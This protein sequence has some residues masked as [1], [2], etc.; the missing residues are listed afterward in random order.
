LNLPTVCPETPV[1]GSAFCDIHCKALREKG[2]EIL[3]LRDF[4]LHCGANPSNY[5]KDDRKK[6]R[7]RTIELSLLIGENVKTPSAIANYTSRNLIDKV[8]RKDPSAFDRAEEIPE[9]MTCTKDLGNAQQLRGHS[10]GILAMIKGGGIIRSWCHIY[11]SESLSQAAL[12]VIA[13]FLMKFRELQESQW[14]SQ[15]F[16][17]SYDNM[18]Q[19]AN[20]KIWRS[21]L[22]L[23]DKEGSRLN[24]LSNMWTQNI[25]KI[26]DVLHINNHKRESCKTL[27]NP[28]LMKNEFEDGN[29]MVCEA[30]FSWLGKYKKIINSLPKTRFEFLLHRLII[31][32][33]QYTE[34]CY[35]VKKY[36]LL[37]SVKKQK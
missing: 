17:L 20:M 8:T 29:S 24:I 26:I 9:E 11:R 7:A 32:R 4:L 27:Y 22:P 30:T 35:R 1:D 6:V 21:P 10:R 14:A 37:P 15:K 13:F 34:Y 3:G 16:Y 19:L 5:T 2:F 31:H 33:N 28:D 23:T 25:T 18:R 12:F 36:P